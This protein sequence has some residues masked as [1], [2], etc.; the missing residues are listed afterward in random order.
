M[1]PIL[2]NKKEYMWLLLFL[3]L[4]PLL[5]VGRKANED[6]LRQE[7]GNVTNRFAKMDLDAQSRQMSRL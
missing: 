6:G 4:V 7:V 3:G 1:N 2:G 5:A